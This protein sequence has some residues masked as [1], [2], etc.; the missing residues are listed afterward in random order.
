M[1]VEFSDKQKKA[2]LGVARKSAKLALA[3]S[4]MS[5]FTS[6]DDL[7]NKNLGCFVTLHNQGQLR[8]C[9]GHFTPSTPLV[10]TISEMGVSAAI[11]D[12]RF[13][14]NP[15]TLAEMDTIDIEISVLSPMVLAEN[16]L[17][18]ELGVHGIYIIS[19]DRG[20]CFLPQVATETGWDKETFLSHCC[21][22]KAGIGAD[23]WRTGE[24]QVYLYTATVFGELDFA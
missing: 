17:D 20:G 7:F 8:G 2:L 3:R 11:K 12:H 24:A 5:A 14:Q 6:E 22:D 18:L 15:V 13:A 4:P 19:G 23:A 1:Q 9:I 21:R 10:A 16:P